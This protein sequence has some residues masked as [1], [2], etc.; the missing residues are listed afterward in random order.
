VTFLIFAGSILLLVGFH[1]AGH[2]FAAKAFGVYVIEFA[3][4]FGPRL[5]AF[6][7]RETR[8]SIRLIPFGGYVRMAGEDRREADAAIPPERL[9][10]SKP[11]MIR[12]II[13]LSG[14]VAN[15]LLA[16]AVTFAVVWT[17][18]FPV[19][20]VAAVIEDTPAA[21]TLQLGDRV[22]SIG[23]RAIYLQDQIAESIQRSHGEEM[24]I[25]IE[26]DGATEALRVR[27]A[28]DEDEE[29][30]FVGAYFHTV[31]YTNELDLLPADSSV[32]AQGA[33]D[34]DRVVAVG[35]TPVDSGVA[36]LVELERRVRPT[37]RSGGRGGEQLEIPV[38]DAAEL[39]EELGVSPPFSNLG[40]ATRHTGFEDGIVLG[41]GQFAENVRMMGD[42]VRQIVTGRVA[43]SEVL[44]G[45]VGVARILGEGF[46]LGP[47]V[48]L[49]ILA[50]LSLN[51]A[52][53]NL[54]P[55][56][57]LDGSRVAFAVYEKLRGRPIPVEREGLIHAVG[58]VVLIGV[59][60][61]VTYKDLVT[62]FR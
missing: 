28:Y 44:Q 25:A 22:L 36:L 9:L 40:I 62:L 57:G 15:L 41:A 13:S 53:L 18:E 17:T 59:M 27:A 61:L 7:G 33:Y 45:P 43:A 23:G 3:V 31:A 56:P 47:T 26:R 42:F 19:L 12:A 58:F 16:L 29:R 46:R 52:L 38:A 5:L 37:S 39:V 20:Q 54:I 50:F 34:G 21:E 24:T 4:G 8:Y 1:E 35:G 2:F 11:P 14:P 30:F 10:Y 60:I 55:F 32:A 6:R 48:F 51:F 49:Q